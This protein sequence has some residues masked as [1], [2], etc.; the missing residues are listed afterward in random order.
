LT[1]EDILFGKAALAYGALPRDAF[2]GLLAEYRGL[3]AK[4]QTD[5]LAKHVLARGALTAEQY[6]DLVGQLQAMSASA[7]PAS[8]AA[9]DALAKLV[10]QSA[11]PAPAAAPA[12]PAEPGAKVGPQSQT[13]AILR[14]KLKVPKEASSFE[15]AGYRKL[16]YL[17]EGALGVVYR[18]KDK[19]GTVV[20]VKAFASA[21][22]GGQKELRRFLQERRVFQGLDHPGVV[23]VHEMGISDDVPFFTMDFVEGKT[24]AKLLEPTEDRPPREKLVEIVAKMCEAVAY[25][26]EKNIVLRDLKPENVIVRDSDGAPVIIEL[27]LAKDVGGDLKLTV[28]DGVTMATTPSYTAL[29][30]QKDPA[31]ATVQSDVFSL[32]VLLYQATCGLLPF[33]AKNVYDLMAQMEKEKPKAP[34][35]LDPASPASLDAVCLKALSVEATKRHSGAQALADDVERSLSKKKG[36]GAAA[37]SGS[38]EGGFFSRLFAKLFRRG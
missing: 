16:T 18:A 33:N 21:G 12:V 36:K 5:S 13:D 32:G 3:R 10:P 34:S 27:G 1:R 6:R 7:D 25:L 8:R 14:K 35:Q 38:S 28:G 19:E 9:T 22:S 26:H 11:A 17:G 4:G 37:S 29:E 31:S 23:K 15:F 24:L 2:N 30:V 20:V